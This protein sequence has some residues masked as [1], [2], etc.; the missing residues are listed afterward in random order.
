MKTLSLL[1][2]CLLWVGGPLFA[3]EGPGDAAFDL[4][5][6]ESIT[7]AKLLYPCLNEEG[8]AMA[9]EVRTEILAMIGVDTM[10][11]AGSKETLEDPALA[12]RFAEF[13]R[14]D[15]PVRIAHRLALRHGIEPVAVNARQRELWNY[16]LETANKVIA[17][18]PEIT[19]LD[20]QIAGIVKMG[21]TAEGMKAQRQM[22]VDRIR[23]EAR[24]MA[25]AQW[26][27]ALATAAVQGPR[28][29]NV[30]D[31]QAEAVKRMEAEDL[32]RYRTWL[33]E[34]AVILLAK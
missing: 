18:S 32:E 34:Q 26:Q 10:V 1:L 3:Q 17:Q 15:F 4:Q 31:L 20:Q 14:A 25:A 22:V 27:K 24:V 21:G 13:E 16:W 23:V 19:K 8:S 29:A 9:M 30:Q 33:A 7:E 2:C 6:E 12:W 11:K 5:R 28:E